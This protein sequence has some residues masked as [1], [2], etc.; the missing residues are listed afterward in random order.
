M[1]VAA[2]PLEGVVLALLGHSSSGPFT[3]GNTTTFA[4]RLVLAIRLRL[5]SR[6]F[7]HREAQTSR[8]AAGLIRYVG[9]LRRS[10]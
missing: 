10:I 5:E 4:D 9:T 1:T 6:E 7:I 2:E 3:A 8:H